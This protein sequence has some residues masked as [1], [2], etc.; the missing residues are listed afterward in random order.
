MQTDTPLRRWIVGRRPSRTAARAVALVAAVLLLYGWV[1]RPVR[2]FGPSMEPT[3]KGG[4]LALVFLR[5][6]A[7]S[8]PSRGDIVAI[9][10]AGPSLVYVKRIVGLP[11]ERLRI[12]RGTVL[13]NG[14]PLIEP[15]LRQAA[16]WM[17]EDLMLGSQE[18]FVIGDNRSMPMSQHTFGR[19]NA[20]RILGKVIW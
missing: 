7:F 3:L 4:R 5:A 10:L 18:Y 6:F 8:R 17:L 16:P 1:L 14:A 11:G 19:V 20:E 2:L 13:V 15:Y 9:R 12:E